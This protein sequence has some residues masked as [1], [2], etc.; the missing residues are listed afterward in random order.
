MLMFIIHLINSLLIRFTFA[1]FAE[2]PLLDLKI[3]LIVPGQ[4]LF[5][6]PV[7]MRPNILPLM[8]FSSLEMHVV[9]HQLLRT[10]EITF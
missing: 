4:L 5:W 3:Q 2:T 1:L 8:F 9:V 6:R 10:R 7:M